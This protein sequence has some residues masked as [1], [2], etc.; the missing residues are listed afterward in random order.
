MDRWIRRALERIFQD[1]IAVGNATNQLEAAALIARLKPV[2]TAGGLHRFGPN[3][4]GGYLMPD[5]LD[6]VVACISPGVSSECGFDEAIASRGIDVLMADASVDGPPEPNP[7]FRFARKFLDLAPSKIAMT[8]DEL[9]VQAPSGGDL[10]LQM[11]IEGAEYR[12]LASMSDQLLRRIRIAIVEFHDLDQVFSRFGI[13]LI[14]P[15]FEKMTTRHSVV[16]IHPNNVVQPVVRGALSVP[17]IMEFTFHRNDRLG[18]KNMRNIS[19][20]HE[21]DAPCVPTKPSYPLPDCW[22]R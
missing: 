5:D 3:G 18:G 15:V 11:D 17:P 19:F 2:A 14:R 22:W 12:V 13:N 6:G 10:I 16:H 9:S 20:P 1:K 21:L 4:D 7:R 8:I